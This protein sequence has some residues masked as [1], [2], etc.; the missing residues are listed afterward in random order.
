[1]TER[2]TPVRIAAG[3]GALLLIARGVYDLLVLDNAT[4]GPATLIVIGFA[5][6]AWAVVGT[7][8]DRS[9]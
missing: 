4:R 7:G 1:M 2:N 8:R 5:M 9:S 6:G 3:V